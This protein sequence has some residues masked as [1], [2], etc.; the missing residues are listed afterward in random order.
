MVDYQLYFNISE[1]IS[2]VPANAFVPMKTVMSSYDIQVLQEWC[3]GVHVSW[4]IETI[5]IAILFL[6]ATY[7]ADLYVKGML[8]NKKTIVILTWTTMIVRVLSVLMILYSL[9]WGVS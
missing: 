9:T 8:K 2:H 7:L 6:L 3:L 1:N 5:R 4:A